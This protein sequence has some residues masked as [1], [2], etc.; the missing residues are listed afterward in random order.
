MIRARVGPTLRSLK[1]LG[2][3]LGSFKLLS[4]SMSYTFEIGHLDIR[5]SR[6]RLGS[7][8]DLVW[9]WFGGIFGPFGLERLL[10]GNGARHA[11]DV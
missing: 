8:D 1:N 10:Y 3:D 4:I 6:V 5:R 11:F 7:A 2:R 9:G